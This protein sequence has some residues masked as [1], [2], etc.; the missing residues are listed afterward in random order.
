MRAIAEFAMRGRAYA[1]AISMVAAA[2]PLLGWLSTVI[3][4]LVCLRH[5]MAQGSLI[6]LWT[7]LPV[8]VTYYFVGDPSPMIAL[9]GTFTM[10]MLLRQTLSWELVLVAS[11]VFSAVGAL[12]FEYSAAGILDRFVQFYIDYL[13][14]VDASIVIDPEQARKLLMGF[15][16][17]GQAFAM[18]VMLIVARW[19]Q[20]TLY[21]L[22]GFRKE[23]HQLRLSPAVSGS[24]VLAM[25]VCYLF[26]DQLGR[27]LPLLTVPLV[28]ASIGLAHW[29]MANRELSKTWV[30]G[31]YGSLVLLFQIVYPFLASLALMDSWFDIRNRIKTIQKD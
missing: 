8:G 10:A 28:F 27:W 5:G 30:A 6:L 7:M 18:V 22:G 26:G 2:L 29:L 11:V 21:N 25:A 24:I 4:A 23:F 1:I 15:F 3:V 12:I 31:F 16:A 13:T 19:C 20:S 14:Q 9:F 17:L